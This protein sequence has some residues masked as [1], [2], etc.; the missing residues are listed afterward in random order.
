MYEKLK[1]LNETEKKDYV[2]SY[3]IGQ[4]HHY[5]VLQEKKN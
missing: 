3:L 2:K 4:I 5:D 1:G